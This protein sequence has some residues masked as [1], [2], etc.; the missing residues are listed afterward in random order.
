L[1]QRALHPAEPLEHGPSDALA[2]E[3][4]REAI[5]WTLSALR[6][7]SSPA[8]SESA[9]LGELWEHTD[10]ELLVRAAGDEKAAEQLRAEVAAKSFVDFAEIAAGKQRSLAERLDQF[11][12]ALLEPLE[13]KVTKLERVWVRRAA[14]FGLLALVL[15]LLIAAFPWLR[16]VGEQRKDMAKAARWQAS[17]KY[18]EGGCVSPA[19]QCENSPQFFFHT[20]HDH[21]PWLLFDLGT[22]RELSAVWVQN[23]MDCCG[24]RALPLVVEVS[25]DKVKWTEVA[26][27]T[28]EFSAWRAAFPTVRTRWVRLSVPRQTFL[29]LK[30]VRLLP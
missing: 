3:L 1:A 22:E 23:R 24:E 11:S 15:G 25:S 7:A 27:R 28:S 4:Y 26:R 14:R 5:F 18:L 17:S 12:G 2:C 8:A 16:E 20:N 13:S 19:Q 9:D 30:T 6:T 29:H 21:N 10:R